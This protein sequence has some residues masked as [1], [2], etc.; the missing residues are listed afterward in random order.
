MTTQERNMRRKLVGVVSSEGADKTVTVVAERM[1][2]HPKYKKYMRRRKKYLAHDEENTAH[3]GDT[4]EL[5]S[6]RPMSKH[7]R[8]RVTRI[9][10]ASVGGAS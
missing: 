3:V 1:Y 8:W 4:V 7:K 6:T 5:T 2:Q 9:V 10:T